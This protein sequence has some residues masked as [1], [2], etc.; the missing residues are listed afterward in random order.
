MRMSVVTHTYSPDLSLNVRTAH[1]F[2]YSLPSWREAYFTQSLPLSATHR[3]SAHW[4]RVAAATSYFFRHKFQLSRILVLY[5]LAIYFLVIVILW[6]SRGGGRGRGRGGIY[7]FIILLL[8]WR[9]GCPSVSENSITPGYFV[10]QNEAY[11]PLART[12]PST[13][14]R[15]VHLV[16][17]ID[18]LIYD[19]P[20]IQYHWNEGWRR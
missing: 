10:R 9:N 15:F 18:S 5:F 14:I 7:S 2:R 3:H 1:L 16:L 13:P 20:Q 6:G 17:I 8:R 4:S 12:V 19:S 11:T